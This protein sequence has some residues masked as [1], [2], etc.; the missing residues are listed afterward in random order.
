MGVEVD[1]AVGCVLDDQD[2]DLRGAVV[3]ARHAVGGV[4]QLNA[5]LLS[6]AAHDATRGIADPHFLIVNRRAGFVPEVQTSGRPRRAKAVRRDRP[7]T[8]DQLHPQFG[9]RHDHRDRGQSGGHAVDDDFVGRVRRL[10]EEKPVLIGDPA[11]ALH[12]VHLPYPWRELILGGRSVVGAG[13]VP[14]VLG[15]HQW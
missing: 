15:P 12:V 4:V 9:A 5:V 14:D 8:V 1:D 2:R 7:A 6:G 13:Q 11:A 10:I 3:E